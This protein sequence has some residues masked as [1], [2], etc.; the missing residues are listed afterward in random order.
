MLVYP[1]YI[2]HTFNRMPRPPRHMTHTC[3]REFHLTDFKDQYTLQCRRCSEIVT[4]PWKKAHPA[5][6]IHIPLK[7]KLMNALFG[8]SDPPFAGVADLGYQK[9]K[10]D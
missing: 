10:S 5:T 4:N 3:G 8:R 1:L 9:V 6:E 7:V 2:P